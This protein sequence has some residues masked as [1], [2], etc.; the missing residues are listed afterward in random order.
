MDESRSDPS[1]LTTAQT[2]REVESLEKLLTQRVE[3]V[4]K[5]VDVAHQNL[6]RVPTDVDK[7]IGHVRELMTERFQTVTKEFLVHLEKFASV[8][9]Q[10]VERD[11]RTEQ[12][13]KDTKVAI[14]A[15]LMA[16][17]KAVG[18]QQEASDRAI[19]KQEGATTKQLEAI[20]SLIANNNKALDDKINDLKERFAA[21][22]GAGSGHKEAA[23][24]QRQSTGSIVSIAGIVIALIVGA[25]GGGFL[26][27]DAPQ[28]IYAAPPATAVPAT[29]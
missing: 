26:K 10:F 12:M 3:S 8:Q 28:V 19:A 29:K 4:E 2:L 18:K 1:P 5:A 22:A 11:T 21:A 17:E 9:T 13:A 16:A 23:T 24:D 27:R 6:V 7:S 25:F 15:A 20:T 14:D